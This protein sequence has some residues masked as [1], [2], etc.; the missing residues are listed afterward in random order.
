MA[1]EPKEEHANSPEDLLWYVAH[2]RPR[3]EKKLAQFCRR[4]NLAAT[5]PCYRV[6]HK[7]RAKTAKTVVFEKPLFP[8]YVFLQLFPQQRQKVRQSDFVARLLEIV[9]QDLFVEQLKAVLHAL[10]NDF[11]IR[12]A[13]EIKEGQRVRITRGPLQG[14]EGWIERGYSPGTVL[15]RINFIG[16]AAAVQLPPGDFEPS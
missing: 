1:P 5:L 11:E 15:L 14:V 3:C 7:Y 13:P 8:G 6:V 9:S 16:Q 10:Q 4:E 12:L 2:T